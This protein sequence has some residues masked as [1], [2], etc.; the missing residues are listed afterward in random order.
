MGE[1]KRRKLSRDARPEEIFPGGHGPAQSDVVGVMKAT[2]DTLREMLPGYQFT[3]F[4][5]ETD[6]TGAAAGRDPRFNY[7]ST[8]ERADMVKVLAAFCLKNRDML[9]IDEAIQRKPEGSA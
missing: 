5:A 3:L 6:E 9:A 8:A 4:V 2:L 1:A 7:M